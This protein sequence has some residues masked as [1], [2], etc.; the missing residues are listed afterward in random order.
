MDGERSHAS[1]G[2]HD[3]GGP[4]GAVA[5]RKEAPIAVTVL[6]SMWKPAICGDLGITLS[7]RSR[8]Q[9]AALTKR[10]G[11]DGVVCSAQEA[12]RWQELGQEFV[13]TPGSAPQVMMQ[14]IS[15][16]S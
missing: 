6:T 5:V 7:C 11:L 10:C 1:G 8:C 16:E 13:N 14:A 2:A 4:R 15:A 9:L 3:D 12:V